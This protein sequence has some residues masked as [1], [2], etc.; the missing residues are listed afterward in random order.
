MVAAAA[1]KG[2][3]SVQRLVRDGV[4]TSLA[5]LF[6]YVARTVAPRCGRSEPGARLDGGVSVSSSRNPAGD[7]GTVSGE[8]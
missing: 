2:G 7:G 1:G 4:G 3:A 6:V 5:N 8:R